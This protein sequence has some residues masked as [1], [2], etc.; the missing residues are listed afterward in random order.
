LREVVQRGYEIEITHFV[1]SPGYQSWI[2]RRLYI[3]VTSK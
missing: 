1:S 2:T 3:F